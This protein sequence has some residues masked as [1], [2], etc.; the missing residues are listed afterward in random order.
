MLMSALYLATT[1]LIFLLLTVPGLSLASRLGDLTEGERLAV[2]TAVS[3]FLL[4]LFVPLFA[5]HLDALARVLFLLI[6]VYSAYR[7]RKFSFNLEFRNMLL[8]FVISVLI[9][10]SLQTLWEYPLMGADWYAHA[11]LYPTSYQLG[12]WAP[13]TRTP[14]F[15]LLLY[16]LHSLLGTSTCSF[17]ISQIASVIMNSALVLPAYLIAEKAF[18]SRVAGFSALL[19]AINPFL[20]ENSIYTWPK[21][22]AAYFVLLMFYFIF[23]RKG[24]KTDYIIAGTLGGLA[25]LGHNYALLYVLSA[26]ALMVYSKKGACYFLLPFLLLQVPHLLWAFSHGSAVT[27][28]LVYYP[29]AV[30]GPESAFDGNVSELWSAFRSTPAATHLGIR[31][32]NA[33]N[34]LLPAHFRHPLLYYY[35]TYPG[36]LTSLLYIF[37]L[38][39][40]WKHVLVKQEAGPYLVGLVAVPFFLTVAIFG[41]PEAGLA[42]ETLHPTIPVLIFLGVS[43]IYG[44]RE[45]RKRKTSLFLVALGCVSEGLLLANWLKGA[46]MSKGLSEFELSRLFSA[47]MLLDSGGEVISNLLT[48]IFIMAIGVY[49][50]KRGGNER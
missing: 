41:F 43:E 20:I 40:L 28:P 17:W 37:V 25:Y 36:A 22:L 50:L 30:S 13:S 45:D 42:R 19:I 47:R 38:V 18:D 46:S 27:S 23:F 3:L 9:R 8:F 21:N 33:F 49:Y 1:A 39:W 16:T 11:F 24:G 48:S 2:S 4:A 31:A 35:F 29:I 14:L 32:V 44:I 10:T 15:S 7:L 12:S 34:T 5:L 6:F 26:F